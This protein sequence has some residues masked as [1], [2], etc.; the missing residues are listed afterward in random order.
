MMAKVTVS[1]WFDYEYD[2]N[3]DHV[4]TLKSSSGLS[5]T[6]TQFINQVHLWCFDKGIEADFV[7]VQKDDGID[8][9]K[10]HIPDASHR[11][12]FMLRWS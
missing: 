7:G 11:T 5:G 4:V 1:G 9:T 3:I 10:W 8:I 12:M 6:L 2:T